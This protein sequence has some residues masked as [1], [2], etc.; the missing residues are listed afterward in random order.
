MSDWNLGSEQHPNGSRDVVIAFVNDDST[1]HVGG[2]LT[3]MGRTFY[4]D[5]NWA[6]SGS[7]PGR[8]YSAFSLWGSDEQAA[9]EYVAAAGTMRGSGSAPDRIDLNLI[10]A[11]S[12]DGQ[13]YGWDGKLLPI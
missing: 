1:G 7:I 8:N 12:G 3:F 6:A 13:Q 11:S 5:G 2:T 4:V 10:R 9:T